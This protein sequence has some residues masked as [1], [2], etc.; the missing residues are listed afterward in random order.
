MIGH[1]AALIP[2]GAQAFQLPRRRYRRRLYDNAPGHQ[3]VHRQHDDATTAQRAGSPS[4]SSWASTS[5]RTTAAPSSGSRTPDLG[6]V[7]W[8]AVGRLGGRHR[9]DA[10]QQHHRPADY[11][12]TAKF[13]LT[14]ALSSAR[15]SAGSSSTRSSIELPRRHGLPRPRGRDGQRGGEP[16]AV[17]AD[18]RSINTTIG[19]CG[20]QQFGWHD[21]LFVTAALRVD[22]NSAFG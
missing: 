3:P 10:P 21:R 9:P 14:S 22:N 1:I 11:A 12:G 8:R 19:A 4:A 16:R 5:R 13:K 17:H 15:R 6:A 7:V 18:R 20:Q 2:S